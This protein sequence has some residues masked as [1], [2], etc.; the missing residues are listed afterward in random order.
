MPNSILITKKQASS[1]LGISPGHLSRL[2]R[3]DKAPKPIRFGA[4]MQH[5]VF[6]LETEIEEFIMQRVAERDA[7]SLT[8][9][10]NGGTH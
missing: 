1:R 8:D 7:S 2:S 10:Q 5:A 9:Y 3:Q 4:T 6:Y